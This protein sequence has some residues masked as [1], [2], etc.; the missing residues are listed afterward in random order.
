GVSRVAEQS[1]DKVAG[2]VSTSLR[3]NSHLEV[4]RSSFGVRP[5]QRTGRFDA[6]ATVNK[7][8][9]SIR[10][11]PVTIPTTN[12]PDAEQN[13]C[14]GSV[15]VATRIVAKAV[16]RATEGDDLAGIGV[17]YKQHITRDWAIEADASLFPRR[18]E[19]SVSVSRVV[20]TKLS[21]MLWVKDVTPPSL[22]ASTSCRLAPVKAPVNSSRIV[23]VAGLELIGP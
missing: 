2:S 18:I 17:N 19:T 1:V 10:D 12:V 9:S 13:G 11:T 16:E 3:V 20:K 15:T 14:A 6:G 7:E 22:E 21:S 5:R 4:N 23:I 8:L